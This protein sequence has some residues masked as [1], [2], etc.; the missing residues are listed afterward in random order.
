MR[1]IITLILVIAATFTCMAQDNTQDNKLSKKERKQMEARIDSILHA[2]AIQAVNDTS[3]VIEADQVNFKRGYTA[4]VTAS[5]NFVAVKE[6]HAIV[7]WRSMYR[8]QDSMD[9]AE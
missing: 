7:Q 2:E 4:H 9:L 8:L 1:I 5:T 3:F 6:G